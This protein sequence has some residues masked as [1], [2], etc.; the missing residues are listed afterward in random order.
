MPS[1]ASINPK[2]HGVD[3]IPKLRKMKQETGEISKLKAQ[4]K[5]LEQ[6]DF[7]II[8][9]IAA[10]DIT[11]R[12]N[13]EIANAGGGMMYDGPGLDGGEAGGGGSWEA[14]SGVVTSIGSEM[15]YS[16]TYG[17]WMGKKFKMYKQTWGRNGF[18]GGKNK[19][20]KTTS[21]AIK[22]GGRVLGAWNAYSIQRDYADGVMGTS[23]MVAEQGTN[24]ISTFGGIFGA[25]WGVGWEL[26]RAITTIDAYQEFKFNFWYNRW[27]S[28][29]GPPSQSNEG[30]WYYFYQN[31]GQ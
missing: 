18:T 13:N 17:I 12:I 5:E 31:Y 10:L 22:W 11:Q 23:W 25:A 27:E 4:I 30:A 14:Y 1:F 28:Q 26:G 3:P 29:V 15:F 24:A 6:G 16:K 2:A 7:N 19:F 9:V 20:G 8:E 21:N